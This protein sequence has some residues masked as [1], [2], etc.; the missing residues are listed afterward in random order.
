MGGWWFVQKHACLRG[1]LYRRICC[2]SCVPPVLCRRL[3]DNL[4]T[5]TVPNSISSMG[6]LTKLY[7]MV[8]VAWW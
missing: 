2:L 4:L 3:Y 6:K 5:G 1:S 7:V 8:M